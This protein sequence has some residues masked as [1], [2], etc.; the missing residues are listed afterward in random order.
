MP[1]YNNYVDEDYW[2]SG[3]AEGDIHSLAMLS[4]SSSSDV[5]AGERIRLASLAASSTGAQLTAGMSRFFVAFTPTSSSSIAS[6]VRYQ[7]GT[8]GTSSSTSDTKN[9]ANI[10]VS[11]AV[12]SSTNSAADISAALRFTPAAQPAA[13]STILA[14]PDFIAR[15]ALRVDASGAAA[16]AGAARLPVSGRSQANSFTLLAARILWEGGAADA[17][18]NWNLVADTPETWALSAENSSEWSELTNTSDTWVVIPDNS[19]NWIP[20][21]N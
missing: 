3:Y 2:V 10:L 15:V 7:A 4:S 17:A 11:R 18:P 14:T 20:L 5:V 8:S 16:A 12:P 1:T 6:A 9:G 13:Q 19:N 21:S